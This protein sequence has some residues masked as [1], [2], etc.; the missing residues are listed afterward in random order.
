MV[1]ARILPRYSQAKMPTATPNEPER[2]KKRYNYVRLPY[3]NSANDLI[4]QDIRAVDTASDWLITNFGST[5]CYSIH[6]SVLPV[7]ETLFVE[8]SSDCLN[9]RCNVISLQ[10]VTK[11]HVS[12]TVAPDPTMSLTHS[13]E[14][15]KCSVHLA[16][17]FTCSVK[18][19][20][21]LPTK[22]SQSSAFFNPAPSFLS[23][24]KTNRAIRCF[25]ME[26]NEL[27]RINN[28]CAPSKF[29]IA[30]FFLCGGMEQCST[31]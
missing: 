19:R 14:P 24:P 1:P 3:T 18:S 6:L 10:V 4:S 27:R 9:P 16:G 23:F 26:E 30:R 22:K 20:S 5:V 28:N 12:S 25:N 7:Q 29:Q 11:T 21:G 31:S 2:T 8:K 15:A 17:F 13:I